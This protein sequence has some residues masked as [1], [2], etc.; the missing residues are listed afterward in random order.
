MG[1]NCNNIFAKVLA[2]NLIRVTEF[3]SHPNQT[4]FMPS[5]DLHQYPQTLHEQENL[6]HKQIVALDITKAS[7]SL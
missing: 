6:P 1:R 4:C 7:D 3:L 5:K 2:M